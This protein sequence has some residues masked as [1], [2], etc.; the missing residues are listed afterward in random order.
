DLSLAS[1]TW[2]FAKG[3]YIQDFA[4]ARQ[5][6]SFQIYISTEVPVPAALPMLLTGIA[7]IALLAR[8]KRKAA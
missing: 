7:G 4:K 2:S 5:L 1:G 8:R 6:K 3:N